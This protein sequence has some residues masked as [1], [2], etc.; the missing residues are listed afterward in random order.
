MSL[1]T[2]FNAIC[3]FRRIHPVKSG[4]PIRSNDPILFNV[5]Q[6]LFELRK[7]LLE[8]YSY[9]RGYNFNVRVSEGMATFPNILHICILPPGQKVSEGIYTA[10]CF[11]KN[12]N[13]AIIGCAESKTNPKGLK[14]IV[15]TEKR[16][17]T[18]DVDG[19]R[20]TTKYNDVFENPKEFIYDN[21]TE[22]EISLQI[23][24][25]LNLSLFNLK[26]TESVDEVQI[27]DYLNSEIDENSL[28]NKALTGLDERKK[29]ASQIFAR[30]GQKKFRNS[31]L[32]S[33]NNICAITDCDMEE[34][35]EA[36]HIFPFK[37]EYTNR[38]T[39]GILLRAD[40][41]T[42]FD[43]GH[44]TIDPSDYRVILSKKLSRN[45]HYKNL[46][47]KKITRP[48]LCNERPNK[49]LLK[50]HFENIFLG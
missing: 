18:I 27:S 6:N 3:D 35:L 8:R 33:Y 15:R 19:G 23:E 38:I 25:S 26:L 31:L 24:K 44:V 49:K 13:G 9:Y 48:E 41:H 17:L 2:N 28:Y 43:L 32:K 1:A 20:P 50:Y 11:D 42:L 29:I 7:K 10:I 21:V 36:A 39:N 46:I 47:G 4:F 45:N 5:K 34:I 30:R 40:I 14:T 22:E 37:G 16:P 12:G